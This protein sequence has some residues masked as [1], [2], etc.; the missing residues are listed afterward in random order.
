VKVCQRKQYSLVLRILLKPRTN[1]F[2]MVL[3]FPSVLTMVFPWPGYILYPLYAHNPILKYTFWKYKYGL[4]NSQKMLWKKSDTHTHNP[5]T[6]FIFSTGYQHGSDQSRMRGTDM[7][8]HVRLWNYVPHTSTTLPS[9]FVQYSCRVPR[10]ANVQLWK[11][12]ILEFN[13]TTCTQ[14]TIFSLLFLNYCI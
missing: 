14:A 3:A 2:F 10:G 12:R 8:V 7:W 11:L 1:I 4:I 9:I 5:T 6:Y 13:I